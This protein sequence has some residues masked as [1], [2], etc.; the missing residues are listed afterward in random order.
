MTD[1]A[2]PLSGPD[3][4][5][6][7]VL[8]DI[9][10]GGILLGHTQGEAV[11]LSRSGQEVF[12]IGAVC[13]HY[14]G[15]LNEGLVVDGTV[16]CPWHHAC[17]SLRT[18]E[19]LAAPALRPVDR[20]VV[21]R[22]G[23]AVLVRAKAPPFAPRR[24]TGAGPGSIV[25]LGA[26]AAGAAAAERLRREGYG[27]PLTLVDAEPDGPVDRPNLSKDYLAGTAPEAWIPL[28]PDDWFS[29]HRITRRFGVRAGAI[30]PAARVVTLA[31]GERLSFDRLLIATGADPAR[32]PIPGADLPHV[33]TLRSLGDSRTLIA[34]AAKARRA[35][36]VGSGFIGLEV[37]ASLRA[38]GLEVD[39]VTPDSRPLQL[40]L[41][42]ELGGFVRQ[43]HEEHGVRFH[44]RAGVEAITPGGVRLVGGG[45]VPA[46]LVVLGVGVRPAVG[47]ASA[48]GLTV[49]GGILVDEFLET[50]VPGIFAAGDVARWPDPRSGGRV[51]V[52]HWA[53]AQR[54]GQVAALN[55][56]GGREPFR[57]VPFFWSQHYD[58][59]IAMVG[60]PAGC[61]RVVARGAP[62]TR[63]CLVAFH[64]KGKVAA[65]AT[66]GRDR[67]SLLAEAAFER[68]DE[69]ALS[70]LV[71]DGG[72]A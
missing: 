21:E 25:I 24:L 19:A 56:L 72:P 62:A 23:D 50:S 31:D 70:A 9:P 4:A 16:R 3:L 49:D 71:A 39:V 1:H 46:E 29:R 45:Q 34:A 17:F 64:R 30:D 54:Q 2:A 67:E 40:Q 41:G 8:A 69:V 22:R 27:G 6:G 28:F 47:I 32:L 7:I 43:L 57:A 14:G 20:W 53:V 44:L 35:V 13:T 12:A 59:T 63:Y 10:D 48:A 11:L 37:A 33:H 52:E 55:L 26:G 38:R 51:R 5:A 15:P 61:D 65:I 36:I 18:G 42:S 68:G 60:D 58:V 66:I